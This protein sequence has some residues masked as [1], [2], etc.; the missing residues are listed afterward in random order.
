MF[1]FA[2]AENDVSHFLSRFVVYG[3]Y[4]GFTLPVHT[5]KFNRRRGQDLGYT[6]LALTSASLPYSRR[7]SSFLPGIFRPNGIVTS[8]YFIKCSKSSAGE[9][10]LLLQ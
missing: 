3:L 10:L 9:Q 4:Y 5:Y 2:Q 6:S 1:F 7:Y 8:F